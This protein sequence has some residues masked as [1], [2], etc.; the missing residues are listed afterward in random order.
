[1]KTRK[2]AP[3]VAPGTRQ[4]RASLAT[5]RCLK[6]LPPEMVDLLTAWERLPYIQRMLTVVAM[7]NHM[8]AGS[9][10]RG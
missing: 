8:A 5:D 2:A 9:Q 7:M 6:K 1:M 3:A 10:P 4:D